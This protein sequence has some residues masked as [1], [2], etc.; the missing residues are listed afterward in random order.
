MAVQTGTAVLMGH[1]LAREFRQVW[2][3]SCFETVPSHQEYPRRHNNHHHRHDQHQHPRLASVSTRGAFSV[4]PCDFR[5]PF[6]LPVPCLT[7]H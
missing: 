7:I 1:L 4:K 5:W 3:G 6:L 2:R